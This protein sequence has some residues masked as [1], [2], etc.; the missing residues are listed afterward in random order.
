[1][2]EQSAVE[3]G[4]HLVLL[5]SV[6][7]VIPIFYILVFKL[8]ISVRKCPQDLMRRFFWKGSELGNDRELA[9]LLI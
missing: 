1:V 5:Q 7:S 9:D 4:Q 6:L 3:G 8:P 2:T